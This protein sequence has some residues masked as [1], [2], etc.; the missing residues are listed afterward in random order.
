LKVASGL[1]VLQ[2]K[3]GLKTEKRP[4]IQGRFQESLV[5]MP[6]QSVL[7]YGESVDL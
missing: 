2:F 1:V 5:A 3:I 4:C 7:L 6:N